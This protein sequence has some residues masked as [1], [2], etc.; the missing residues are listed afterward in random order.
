LTL[1]HILG[2]GSN[3]VGLWIE[4]PSYQF[5]N[6]ESYLDTHFRVVHVVLIVSE[7]ASFLGLFFSTS[8]HILGSGLNGVGLWV[9]KKNSRFP[10]TESYLD[11]H[12]RVVHVVLIVS[13]DM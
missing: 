8:G 2:S 11:T 4:K 5:P 6:M 3:G 9:E 7:D 1:G 12:L 10:N 13:E